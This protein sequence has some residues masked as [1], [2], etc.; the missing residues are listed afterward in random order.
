MDH[1]ELDLRGC[2]EANRNYAELW[3]RHALLL[4]ARVLD[5][6]YTTVFESCPLVSMFLE[7][8][9]LERVYFESHTALDLSSCFALENVEFS[10]CKI[11]VYEIRCPPSVKRLSMVKCRFRDVVNGRHNDNHNRI[12]APSLTSLKID[13]CDGLPPVLES[14]PSLQ[15]AS[16]SF[17]CSFEAG[18]TVSSIW[19]H[20]ITC[21]ATSNRLINN[22]INKNF[23][24]TC[25]LIRKCSLII[26]LRKQRTKSSCS[27]VP[28]HRSL[29]PH[30]FPSV[31]AIPSSSSESPAPPRLLSVALEQKLGS[32][33][34]HHL[35]IQFSVSWSKIEKTSHRQLQ[36]QSAEHKKG[37]ARG[38]MEAAVVSA[39]HGALGS[40]IA[41]L[42]DL[43]TSEYKL[44]KEA[45][46]QIMFLKAELESMHAFLKK[47]SDMEEPDEQ[48]KCWV[49]E[50]REL[51]YDI[52]DSINE[53]LHRVERK[54][55]SMPRGFKG[56]MD[57]SMSLLTT[58]NI[59][60]QIAKELEGL[61]SRVM[62][63]NE[64]RMRYKVD[65]TVSKPNNTVVDSRVLALHAESASLV[66]IEE[67]RD[68][69]IK[70]MEEESVP[71]SHKLKVLS[72]VGFGGLGKTT[73]ANE[74]YRKQE[75]LFLCQAF[76]S[77]SQKPNI[78]K[79][80]RT[81]LSQVGF[82]P[83]M[84]TNMEMWEES[85]LI[86]TLQNFLLDKR[87]FIVI[88]D[89]W[90]APSWDIIRCG[91]PESM[92]GSRVITTTRIETVARACCTNCYEYVYKMKPL[93][94]QGSR[95]N[96]LDNIK[97]LRELTNLTNVEIGYSDYT[98][99]NRDK[100]AAKCRELVHALGNICSLKCLLIH[101]DYL[102][103][104][105]R[106]CLDSW[107]SVPTSFIHLQSFHAMYDR[108]FSRIPGWIGQHHSLYDLELSVQDV[109][110]DDVGILSQLPSLVR[111]DLHIH[112]V[113]KDKIIIRG[114]GFPALK[115]FTVGCFRIS[116]LA[117]E[118]GAM[119]KLERLGLCFNAQGWDRYGGV[120]AGIEYL[121]G[122]KEIVGDIGSTFAKESNRR[123]AE[124]ALRDVAGLHPGH[125]VSNIKLVGGSFGYSIAVPDIN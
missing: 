45:K 73:L 53:F 2:K 95:R 123:A 52:D 60:H 107:C 87:Y 112:G 56:F 70:L 114:R 98:S 11:G 90:D 28:S 14:M 91:L 55:S 65:E 108:W 58:M 97:G 62:E 18:T 102:P 118:A 75:G 103:V 110:G 71:A 100:F 115:H 72:I 3:I 8:L 46:G 120:P 80:L 31:P 24:K 122:L 23:C 93:N 124:S 13:G 105:L 86:R 20:F 76:V 51:S 119:P 32:H 74:I 38:S 34:N 10:I 54:Y 33:S 66:G 7:V 29:W 92:N 61:R 30:N 68:Q 77:V 81:I 19:S 83:P 48:D 36:I 99:T 109:Y 21:E 5:V 41:K 117:F 121:S 79:V 43:I 82:K 101:S 12:S 16:V 42:G 25:F 125:P 116:Y 89:I 6:R 15:A 35:T 67:P 94:E 113:P 26:E 9:R 39:S 104:T 37:K 88:D 78:R 27:F 22:T 1:C 57:R 69:L 49:K 106:A 40:L 59:R 96:S 44:L 17:G 4:Q 111:L 85:E 63:V 47:M 84:N 50:V 64:R